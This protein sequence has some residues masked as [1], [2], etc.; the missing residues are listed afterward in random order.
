[1]RAEVQSILTEANTK[2]SLQ[3]KASP[4]G[5]GTLRLLIVWPAIAHLSQVPRRAEKAVIAM[6]KL[7]AAL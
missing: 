2:I 1:M 3:G 5:E 4:K 7:C 6:G